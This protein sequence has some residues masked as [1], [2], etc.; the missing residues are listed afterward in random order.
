MKSILHK[1]YVTAIILDIDG[2]PLSVNIT[3]WLNRLKQ[4][5]DKLPTN[6]LSV[7]D[8]FVGLA[9]KRMILNS[10][11]L[12]I[13]RLSLKTLGTNLDSW[14]EVVLRQK[15]I[16]FLFLTS[17]RTSQI[18]SRSLTYLWQIIPFYHLWIF[19]HILFGILKQLQVNF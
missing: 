5:V 8:H 1:L 14:G 16:S 12:G 15:F 13:S 2:N 18:S 11:N 6:C 7:F 17:Y 3:E 19:L 4:F 9:L 10:N